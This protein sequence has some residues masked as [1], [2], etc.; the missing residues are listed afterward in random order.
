MQLKKRLYVRV[1]GVRVRVRVG[2]STGEILSRSIGS[3]KDPHY[4]YETCF[5]PVDLK[6]FP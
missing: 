5:L 3:K 4:K 2:C 6:K 1:M